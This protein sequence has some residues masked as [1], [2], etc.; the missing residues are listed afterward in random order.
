MESQSSALPLG[1]ARHEGQY[2]TCNL[3]LSILRFDD[4][5]RWPGLTGVRRSAG[6]VAHEPP[7]GDPWRPLGA[8]GQG[9]L[10]IRYWAFLGLA[11]A[12]R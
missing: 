11:K 12:G 10:I 8:L 5:P 6:R 4:P 7:E 2:T 9:R 3:W 1:Y